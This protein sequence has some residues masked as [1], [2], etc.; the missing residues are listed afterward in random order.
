MG[1]ADDEPHAPEATGSQRAQ[2]ARPEGAV[3]GVP[4]G[5]PQD[6]ALAVAGHPCGDDDGLGHHR[7][8]LVGLDVGGVEE[9]VGERDMVE[10]AL[11]E[12]RHDRI[13]FAA[14]AGDLAL[15]DA[16]LDAQGDDEVVDLA[17]RDAVD[18]GLHDDR[19]E[20]PVDAPAGFEEGWEEA[21]LAELGDVQLDIAGLRG[22]EARAVAVAVG[23]A[24]VGALVAT[25]TDGLGGLELDELLEDEAHRLA[26]RVG[27]ITGA[28]RLEQLGQ[29][30]L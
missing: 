12:V 3:L 9:D 10:A 11:P 20:G 21:A 24:L 26:Q 17:R 7:R 13:E 6:L 28:D 22:Q 4:D 19:P 18:V 14:D 5:E 16:S 29:G 23:G 15:G 1:I 2:E 8:S 27:A 25:G 30:R